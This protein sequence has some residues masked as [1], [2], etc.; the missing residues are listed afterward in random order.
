[1]ICPRYRSR[2]PVP[3]AR[4]EFVAVTAKENTGMESSS[5]LAF[6]IFVMLSC[7]IVVPLAAIFGSAF[8]DVVKTVLVDRIVALAG[9]SPRESG[10][11]S[12]PG[13]L[14]VRPNGEGTGSPWEAPRWNNPQA[15][16]TQEQPAARGGV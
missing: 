2:R 13:D 7:L 1:M 12:G 8:P 3:N 14:P 4:H 6:R 16:E 5:V 11:P 10:K 15:P 9:G